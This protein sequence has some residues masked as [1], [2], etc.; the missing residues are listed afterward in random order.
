MKL[1]D[2]KLTIAYEYESILT[3][4][5]A[6]MSTIVQKQKKKSIIEGQDIDGR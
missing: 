5:V 4:T 1:R 3:S 2:R 6:I